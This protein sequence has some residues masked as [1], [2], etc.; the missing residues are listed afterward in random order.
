LTNKQFLNFADIVCFNFA[1][2][3]EGLTNI[4]DNVFQIFTRLEN[5][6]RT[7]LTHFNLVEHGKNLFS[8]VENELL[9]ESDLFSICINLFTEVKESSD[10]F[11]KENSD[12]DDLLKSLDTR[13]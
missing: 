6:C 7:K 2:T 8:C 12:I 13:Y 1:T 10:T 5:L 9:N 4:T 3:C 11:E